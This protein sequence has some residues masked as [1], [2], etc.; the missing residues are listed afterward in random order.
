MGYLFVYL[1][2]R[3][4]FF[5]RHLHLELCQIAHELNSIFAIQITLGMAV[6]LLYLIQLCHIYFSSVLTGFDFWTVEG[7]S[8]YIWMTLYVIKLFGLNYI[9]E[10]VCTKVSSLK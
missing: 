8:I 7:F 3:F 4:L 6:Y 9:C 1:L 10:S 2:T 5:H